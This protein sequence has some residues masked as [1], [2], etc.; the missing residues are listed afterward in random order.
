MRGGEQ[1]QEQ[2]LEMAGR[3]CLLLMFWYFPI[4]LPIKTQVSPLRPGI[5]IQ[6]LAGDRR[7]NSKI[8]SLFSEEDTQVEISKYDL[9]ALQ[10]VPYGFCGSPAG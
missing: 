7:E 2:I 1:T 5:L 10:N 3:S 8:A 6:Q 4:K 9:N